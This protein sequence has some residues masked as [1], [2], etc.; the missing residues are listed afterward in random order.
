MLHALTLTALGATALALPQQSPQEIFETMRARQLERWETVD[1]YTVFQ[2]MSGIEFPTMPGV[3]DSGELETPM[4]YQKHEIGERVAFGIVPPNEYMVAVGQAGE[5]GEYVNAEFFE[6]M[7][8][9]NRMMADVLDAEISK[10]GMPMLPGMNYGGD[11]LR[12]NAVF[13]DAGAEAIADAEAGDFGR[14]NAAAALAAQDEMARVMRLVGREKVG[15][16][17]A[18]HLRKEGLN[19]VL[20]EPGDEYTFTL[21]SVDAWIDAQHYVILRTLMSGEIEADGQKRDVTLEHLSEDY[22]ET[23]PLFESHRQV[24]RMSGMMGD[25]DPKQREDLEKAMRQMEEMKAQLDQMPEAARGMIERQIATA[26]A[27]MGMLN[28]DAFELVTEVLR[29]EI[30]TGPPPPG[31][32]HKEP[33][34]GR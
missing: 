4:H 14:G 11:M 16:S 21:R 28:N 24:M 27:Q 10:S 19:R 31:T 34:A 5:G 33:P 20:S 30:N 6:A 8:D 25:M 23:G 9:G 2:K 13:A 29:I 26:E 15:R 22:R 12:D 1:N 18:F 17:E 3:T 7:G 32:L